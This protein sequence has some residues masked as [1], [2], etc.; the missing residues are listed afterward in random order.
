MTKARRKP[1]RKPKSITLGNIWK[2]PDALWERIFPI[3]REF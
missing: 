1:R 3:L 2:V